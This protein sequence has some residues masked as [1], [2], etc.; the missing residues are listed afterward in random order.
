MV[1]RHCGEEAKRSQS[2]MGTEFRRCKSS[3]E[4]GDDGGTNM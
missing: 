2:L 4:D 3:G 1:A